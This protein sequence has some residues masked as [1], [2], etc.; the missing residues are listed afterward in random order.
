MIQRLSFFL[1]CVAIGVCAFVILDT[2]RFENLKPI[3]KLQT[4]WE[5]DVAQMADAHRFPPGWNSIREIV[6][7]P[8]DDQAK[9]WL[10]D[11]QIPVVVHKDGEFKLQ[12]MLVTWED[13]EK[14]GVYL[15][16]DMTDLKSPV[17][18]T[19]WE[20]TRTFILSDRDS[21][22]ERV[23]KHRNPNP[24]PSPSVRARKS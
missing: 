12:V 7:T 23:F 16:Y 14:T 1:F 10:H 4:L 19:V 17:E 22:F 20:D 9:R 11:L 21:W 18:N 6:L 5:E 2:W 15:Q 8:G 13:E 24:T 3:S